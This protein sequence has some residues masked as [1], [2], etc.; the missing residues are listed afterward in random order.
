[1]MKKLKKCT[2]VTKKWLRKKQQNQDLVTWFKV[3]PWVAPTWCCHFLNEWMSLSGPLSPSPWEPQCLPY[4]HHY[5][6]YFLSPPPYFLSPP[7]HFL[8]PPPHF[9]SPLPHFL[10][11]L[12]IN[13]INFGQT[14]SPSH[15]LSF[16]TCFFTDTEPKFR[17]L[18]FSDIKIWPGKFR[19]FVY[20]K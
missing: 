4:H 11:H 8:S 1:M 17:F 5:P 14:S 6:P 3:F 13:F 20:L 12:C 19:R 10:F 9:L 2:N 18:T 16:F 7:S 15:S